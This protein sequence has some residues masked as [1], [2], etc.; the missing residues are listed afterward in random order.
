MNERDGVLSRRNLLVG[1]G[2]SAAAA[3]YAAPGVPL[4]LLPSSDRA[5]RPSPWTRQYWTLESAGPAEWRRQIGRSFY[6]TGDGLTRWVV[7]AQ[8]E[9]FASPG[10]RPTDVGR[11]EAFSVLFEAPRPLPFKRE[12]IYTV[13]NNLYRGMQIFL[14]GSDSRRVRAIFN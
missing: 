5:G 2:V 14:G 11:K 8:V 7:L 3:A 9:S 12:R 10:K 13:G 1:V 4:S 6:I